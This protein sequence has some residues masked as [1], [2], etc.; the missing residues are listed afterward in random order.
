LYFYCSLRMIKMF[1]RG[2]SL[3]CH[4]LTYVELTEHLVFF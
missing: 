3:R 2:E 1:F 4:N